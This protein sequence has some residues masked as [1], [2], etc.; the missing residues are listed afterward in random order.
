MMMIDGQEYLSREEAKQVLRATDVHMTALVTAGRLHPR[1]DGAGG[2]RWYL[3][4]ELARIERQTFTRAERN[5]AKRLASWTA[6]DGLR[7]EI[8]NKWAVERMDIRTVKTW[9]NN[10]GVP[11]S[12]YILDKWLHTLSDFAEVVS[13]KRKEAIRPVK[14]PPPP[15]VAPPEDKEPRWPVRSMEDFSPWELAQAQAK[16][17]ALFSPTAI[18]QRKQ[19][20][21]ALRYDQHW[22]W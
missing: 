19:A 5:A 20:H 17:Q 1:R 10:V 7:D 11:C 3:R 18:A 9:L 4:T 2:K 21:V 8:Y 22:Q 6:M 15:P 12:R 14:P 16:A 13:V